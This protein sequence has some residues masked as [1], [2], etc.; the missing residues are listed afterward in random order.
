[1]G[2]AYERVAQS[3]K[4]LTERLIK[5]IESDGQLPWEQGWHSVGQRP[6]NPV[7][8]AVYKGTNRMR[9]MM[10]SYLSGYSDNRWVT[11][12]QAKEHEWHIKKGEKGILCE[13]WIFEEQKIIEDP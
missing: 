6:Y 11:F 12:N 2:K 13:K 8:T 10:G 7:S 4:E 9:L 1:M 3:R 5:I